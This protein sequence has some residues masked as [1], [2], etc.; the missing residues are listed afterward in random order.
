MPRAPKPAGLVLGI[1]LDVTSIERIT[2]TLRGARGERFLI[3]VFTAGEREFCDK[4]KDRFAAYAARFAA[5]E[6][7]VKALGVPKGIGW[8]DI[9][10]VRSRGAPD[11]SFKNRAAEVLAERGA[12]AQLSLSHDGGVA[13]AVVL[14]TT[15]GETP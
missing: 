15:A 7:F 3:R 1:G 11:F 2:A 9:E 13:V 12:R 10:V 4:R 5:K 8:L 14:V 6:A